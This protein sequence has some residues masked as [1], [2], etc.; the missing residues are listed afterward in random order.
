[1]MSG[2]FLTALKH[3]WVQA[4]LDSTLSVGKW[5]QT[6]GTRSRPV[7]TSHLATESRL[8]VSC[9]ASYQFLPCPQSRNTKSSWIE[10]SEFPQV[11]MR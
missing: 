5:E 4:A 1:M 11:W 2:L 6:E 8:I 3:I 9:L 7:R 10:A